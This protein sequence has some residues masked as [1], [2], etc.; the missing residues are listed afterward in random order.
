M[1]ATWKGGSELLLVRWI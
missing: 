1:V